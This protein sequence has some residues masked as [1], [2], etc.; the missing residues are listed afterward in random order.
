M[1]DTTLLDRPIWSSLVSHWKP[2]AIG[3]EAALKLDPACG[4]FAAAADSSPESLAGLAALAPQNGTIWT[5]ETFAHV[6]PSGLEV[7]RTAVL[8]QMTATAIPSAPPGVVDIVPLG[9]ADAEEMFA[10]ATLTQ[11]GPYAPRTNRLG[12]FIGVRAKGRLVA[13]AGERMR[14]P[15]FV[16]VS[17]ICT[18]PDYRGRG[19][20]AALTAVTMRR[21]ADGGET[22]F[23]HTYAS[24]AGA[25]ALYRKLG[26]EPRRELIATVLRRAYSMM[27][28]D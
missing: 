2:L 26:F 12:T 20:A 27:T 9:E 3:G 11:P 7:E 6:A 10:L 15:G 19:L 13:M 25:I 24:N 1:P 8:L 5:V 17:G 23:L 21:I 22:P 28:S 14:M 18:H 4:P 16:E